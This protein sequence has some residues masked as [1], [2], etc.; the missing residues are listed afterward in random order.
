[1]PVELYY[2]ISNIPRGEVADCKDEVPAD[3]IYS[4]SDQIQIRYIDST[5]LI[6]SRD[7]IS[8]WENLLKFHL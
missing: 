7:N 3:Q 8:R 4:I 6:H 1:M 2:G 5:Y